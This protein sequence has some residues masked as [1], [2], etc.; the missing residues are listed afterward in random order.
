MRMAVSKS[1]PNYCKW[2]LKGDSTLIITD[3]YRMSPDSALKTLDE[4][5]GLLLTGGNDIQPSLYGMAGEQ[6]LCDT[7]DPR[8]DTLEKALVTRAIQR[9]IPVLGI[10]RGEQMI[11]V[12]LGGTLILDIPYAIGNRIIHR[13]DDYL[14]CYHSVGAEPGSFLRMITGADSGQVTTNHHQAADRI[15]P[16]LR[17]NARSADGLSEGVEW[18]DRSGK[19]FLLGVQWHP[20]RMDTANPFS[21]KILREFLK[22]ASLYSSNKSK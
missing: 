2:L 3:L 13:C 19:S 22:N 9:G 1:S 11:N 8:R 17:V 12:A 5:S 4:C 18:A 16:G 10:C 20:E 15:A 6:A 7:T 21:G 14:H